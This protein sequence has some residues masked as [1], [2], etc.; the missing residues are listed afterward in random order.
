VGVLLRRYRATGA[1]L[2]FGDPRGAHGVAMEGYFWR[3][4]SAAT[5]RVI[6]VLC[7]ILRSPT[8]PWGLVG[9]ASH[10][11]GFQRELITPRA[12]A[13]SRGVDVRSGTACVADERSLRVDLGPDARLDV[14][15]DDV[16]PFAPRPFGGLGPAHAI[17]GLSQYWHPHV[18]GGTVRG[19]AVLGDEVVDLDGAS[20]YAEKNWSRGGFPDLWW[21]GQAQGFERPDVCV[22]F[23][24]GDVQVGPLALQATALVVRVGDELVRLGTP[25]LTPVTAT[26]GG[27]TWHLRGRS[28]TWSVELFGDG[29]AAEPHL[30]PAERRTVYTAVEHLGAAVDVEVRR[31]GRL[32][33]A[34]SSQLAG[35]EDGHVT[36][37][38]SV[39]EPVAVG[40]PA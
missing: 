10:P 38:P 25:V 36:S 37:A 7:G 29:R 5:G 32:V 23:A 22:A 11:G 14:R 13:A 3:L 19:T 24:G 1:D 8:G 34:G 33:F 12:Q 28:R 16:T 4:T 26:V 2:P 35:L 27:R 30:L 39:A 40:V 15:F 6:I 21:W 17:P 20:V 31:R 9:M 18:L